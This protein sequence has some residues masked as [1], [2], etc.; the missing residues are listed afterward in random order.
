[1]AGPSMLVSPR[2]TFAPSFGGLK[3]AAGVCKPRA[4]EG[5]LGAACATLVMPQKHTMTVSTTARRGTGRTNR[6]QKRRLL[7]PYLLRYQPVETTEKM[8]FVNGVA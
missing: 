4:G 2:V 6:P 8:W 7:I 3:V 1:M 5:A